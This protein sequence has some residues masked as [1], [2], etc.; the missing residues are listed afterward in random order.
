MRIK[1]FSVVNR[2]IPSTC[3]GLFLFLLAL[4]SSC[5]DSQRKA[6][7]N[8]I[9][10]MMR[11]ERVM[12]PLLEQLNLD[13]WEYARTG[14]RKYLEHSD[15]LNDIRMRYLNNEKDFEYLCQLR[16]KGRIKDEYLSRQLEILYRLYLNHQADLSLQ[17]RVGNLQRYLRRE[18]V[19]KT[20][21]T[22]LLSTADTAGMFNE[23]RKNDIKDSLMA[24]VVLRNEWA[25][26]LGF[27][28][29]YIM[30]LFMD[31]QNPQQIDSLFLQLARQTDSAF[32]KIKDE[33]PYSWHYRGLFS[34]YGQRHVNSKRNDAYN[35]LNMPRF[36]VRFF[37]GIGLE[38]EDI[39][40]KSDF[41]KSADK[42]P[43]FHCISVDR[44]DDIRVIGSLYGTETD[45][46]RLF[47]CCGDAVYW[48]YIPNT[49]PFLLRTPSSTM[50]EMGVASFFSRVIG[51]PEW[52][53]SMGIFSAGQAGALK[54]STNKEF[55]ET[56]L[57]FCRWSLLMYDFERQLYA[58]PEA[59]L[60]ALWCELNQRYLFREI[61]SFPEEPYFYCP[62]K[63]CVRKKKYTQ[64]ALRKCSD[65]WI[66]PYFLLDEC[67]VHNYLLA[68]LWAAQLT[69]HLCEVYPKLG[70]PCNPVLV[71]NEDVGTH[72]R[73]YVFEPGACL[74]WQEITRNATGEDLSVE[75]FVEQF[76]QGKK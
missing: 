8:F 59:D 37:A 36:A 60:S 43:F 74:S 50:L 67:Q 39:L 53:L 31:E 3:F 28:D 13:M 11:H 58:N 1:K 56:Q 17:K 29:Y 20:R 34:R 66:E 45:M 22:E 40:A 42:L 69:S 52:L 51:Y 16:K 38:L 14:D 9:N 35:Y 5:G 46:F 26:Q 63:D 4:L 44:K 55:V 25:K 65:W 7:T 27:S 10:F 62:K 21:I 33:L 30:R 6:E 12:I 32:M 76:C 19:K 18:V 71:G 23:L 47:A 72:L 2:L 75:S 41:S 57:L 68:E 15:S 64:A 48:R 73:K 61:M 70:D 24:L 54:G 49:L